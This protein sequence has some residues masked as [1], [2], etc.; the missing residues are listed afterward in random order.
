M[1]DE[2]RYPFF[3]KDNVP[4][5]VSDDLQ[6]AVD[7]LYDVIRM[8][9]EIKDH[10]A[11]VKALKETCDEK[12]A[13]AFSALKRTSMKDPSI[14][15]LKIRTGKNSGIKQLVLEEEL[16]QAGVDAEVLRKARDAATWEKTYITTSFYPV[17]KKKGEE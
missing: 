2:Q 16:L 9:Q 14:G 8:K 7:D 1:T 12:A 11:A 6:W 10:E 15:T 17:R 4:T 3:D 5:A 13:I